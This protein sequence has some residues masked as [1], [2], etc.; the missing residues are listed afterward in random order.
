MTGSKAESILAYFDQQAELDNAHFKGAKEETPKEETPRAT[1]EASE[2]KRSKKKVLKLRPSDLGLTKEEYKDPVKLKAAVKKWKKEQKGDE[3]KDEGDTNSRRHGRSA[4]P[5]RGMSTRSRSRSRRVLKAERLEREDDED[6]LSVCS[7][8]SSVRRRR[9][10]SKSRGRLGA[11]PPIRPK[12]IS[13]PY[14]ASSTDDD[15]SSL[16]D[17]S[18][19][20]FN[21]LNADEDDGNDPRQVMETS[22]TRGRRTL[23]RARS[24]GRLRVKQ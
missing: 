1:P 19:S 6:N 8:A 24:K 20:G 10:R 4:A 23:S 16:S 21:D 11:Q 7:S 15:D 12:T 17:D 13:S 5:A 3:G 18:G 2:D 14:E 9:A 22:Q